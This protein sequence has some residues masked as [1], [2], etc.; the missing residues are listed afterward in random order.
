MNS[1]I[2]YIAYDEYSPSYLRIKRD[3]K[4]GG[5]SKLAGTVTGNKDSQGYFRFNFLGKSYKVHRVVWQLHFGEIPSGLLVDHIDGNPSNNNIKNLRLVTHVENATNRKQ[6]SACKT[7]TTGVSFRKD[8][9]CWVATY[10][11]KNGSRCTKSYSVSRYGE[12]LAEFLALETRDVMLKRNPHYTER[13]G[14]E[15]G[16]K[17]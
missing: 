15:Y 17:E 10:T 12:E 5:G 3:F 7:G 4:N 2:D 14:R 1:L 8:T 9:N 13:H 16:Y 11:D 6:T